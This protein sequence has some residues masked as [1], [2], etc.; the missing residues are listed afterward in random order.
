MIK[1]LKDMH[2]MTGRGE[3]VFASSKDFQSPLERGW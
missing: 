3:F 2:A 1:L